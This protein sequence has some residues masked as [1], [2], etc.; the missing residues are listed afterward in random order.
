[1]RT[2]QGTERGPDPL[3]YGGA[4]MAVAGTAAALCTLGLLIG[5][6][7]AI[8]KAS[9]PAAAAAEPVPET[10]TITKKKTADG[11]GPSTAGPTAPPERES[12]PTVI[13]PTDTVY[14]I[15]WGDTLTQ[16]SLETG[17]SVGRL[18]EYNSIPDAD[19]IYA[20]SLMNIPYIL[21]PAE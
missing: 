4:P 3:A 7:L 8:A 14:F 5:G 19:L 15:E 21:V 12:A 18:A 9:E 17:V 11:T 6:P 20:E 10:G 13:Q 1:M 16:I 2:D